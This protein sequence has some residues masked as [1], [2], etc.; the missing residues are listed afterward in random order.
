MRRFQFPLIVV[1]CFFAFAFPA[2]ASFFTAQ[3]AINPAQCLNFVAEGDSVTLGFGA[4]QPYPA[5]IATALGTTGFNHGIGSTGWNWSTGAV[6]GGS[7]TLTALAPANIDPQLATLTCNGVQ[8][9]LLL[10]G[11]LID[12]NDGDTAANTFTSFQ[13][14]YNAR[15]AF[16]WQASKIIVG[17]LTVAG[18]G[19][20]K[21]AAYNA[22]LIS[23]GFNL[24]RM[25]LDS[26]MGC[27][28]CNLS[29]VY[30]QGDNIHPTN[31][32][33]GIIAQI[34]CYQLRPR[35]GTCPAY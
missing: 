4:T 5:T 9:Y 28:T 2:I 7:L 6:Q 19:T 23:G 22:S 29:A 15:I 25:D 35:V 3:T 14:Y 18:I 26:N 24:A 27:A 13:T 34:F 30:W 1:L 33:L 16:G 32:G 12:M 31:L 8:P 10:F 11:G 20:A 17:T 21:Q